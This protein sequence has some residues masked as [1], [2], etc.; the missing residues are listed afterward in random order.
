MKRLFILLSLSFLFSD[1]LY[2]PGEYS[3][4]QFAIDTSSDGDTIL[5]SAGTFYEN[6]NINNKNI[7]ITGEDKL[8]TIIDGSQFRNAHVVSINNSESFHIRNLSI[9]NGNTNDGAGLRI[10]DSSNIIIEDCII[11]DNISNN[12]GAGIESV[13]ST[14]QIIS[15]TFHSNI[16]QNG[17]SCILSSLSDIHIKNS[18]FFMIMY[19]MQVVE[20]QA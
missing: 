20:Y 2:V 14:L 8:S 12:N 16:S 19:L 4:I 13:N 5:L 17:I 3:T 6:I 18:L 7:I 1:A 10:Y 15:T 11:A 9:K